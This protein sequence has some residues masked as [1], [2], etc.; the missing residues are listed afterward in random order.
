M[1]A[2]VETTG[3]DDEPKSS[4]S[5]QRRL[6]REGYALLNDYYTRVQ[7]PSIAE[8]KELLARLHVLPGCEH[9]TTQNVTVWF[10]QKR[11]S[12][13]MKQTKARTSHDIL[14]PSLKSPGVIED[15]EILTSETPNPSEE[16]VKIWSQ[17]LGVVYSEV[18]TWIAVKREKSQRKSIAEDPGPS[19]AMAGSST[20]LQLLT[21]ELSTSPEPQIHIS[22][23]MSPEI[24][25]NA[26]SEYVDEDV[27]TDIPSHSIPSHLDEI[28][29]KALSNP[30]DGSNRPTTFAEFAQWFQPKQ[31]LISTFQGNLNNGK[32]IEWGLHPSV[33]DASTDGGVQQEMKS[34]DE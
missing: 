22:P 23:A 17:R 19:G 15:L 10:C 9:Y 8:R 18:L 26:I 20:R 24:E 3:A 4:R 21:P 1:S 7:R 27:D 33:G 29:I 2:N 32:Y 11:K 16:M 13:R 5:A 34:E 25:Q 14:Y 30:E 28:L 31:Q 6:T 12:E